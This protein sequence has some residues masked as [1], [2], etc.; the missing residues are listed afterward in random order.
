MAATKAKLVSTA[1]LLVFL[2]SSVGAASQ[3]SAVNAPAYAWLN[4]SLWD[5]SNFRRM[6]IYTVGGRITLKK[7][8][9]VDKS[10][11]LS[12]K[13]VVPPF[14]EAHN[15]N[16]GMGDDKATIQ[17]YLHDGIFY[18][19]TLSNVPRNRHYDEINRPDSIDAVFSNGGITSPG[20]HP[21]A[22]VRRNLQQGNMKPE[23]GEG[24]F[25]HS[26]T[27]RA[28]VDLVLTRLLASHPD[29][30]KIFLVYS[31]DFG[32]PHD[33]NDDRHG[34]DPALVPYIV[35]KAH[36]AKKRVAAHVE[37]SHDFD[38]AINAGADVIAHMP[39]F[40]PDPARIGSLGVSIYLLTQESVQ[41]AARNHVVVITT[42]NE[43]L[44]WEHTP[45]QQPQYEA[46][47][48]VARKNIALLR[49][50]GVTVAAGSDRFRGNS[51]Q[52]A[53]SLAN[54]QVMSNA[55]TLNALSVAAPG[56]IFPGRKIGRLEPGWE[57]S[58][59][60]LDADPTKDIT[61]IRGIRYRVKQG[62]LVSDTV[63]AK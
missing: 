6:D 20:G 53:I 25:I 44:E 3:D 35:H 1:A 34:L 16:I 31:E 47:V 62:V 63:A 52:E 26:A 51:I 60:V 49:Q 55:D 46:I 15:H 4:G 7:P 12:G 11:D 56:V 2:L 61:A 8:G 40:W 27:T 14:G 23:D 9:R 39:G 33:A 10:F 18:V 48:E 36:A 41:K 32:A 19:M 21:H 58:F 22:L 37:S 30:I 42:L 5:G 50:H 45:D 13:F 57:A 59:L 28:D 43:M 29:I 38:V 17:R 24:G 54:H